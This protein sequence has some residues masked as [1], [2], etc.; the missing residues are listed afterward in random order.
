MVRYRRDLTPG[1][2]WFFTATLR[3]RQSDLLVRHIDELRHAWQTMARGRPVESIATVVLPD[4]IH[5]LWRLPAD[6]ADYSS[7]W[8]A[9][10]AGFTRLLGT[11]SP[12]QAR[13]WEHRIRD[14]EDLRRH[15]DYIHFNPVRHGLVQCVGDWPHSS[16][17]RWVSE[18]RL[19]RAW[20]EVKAMDDGLERTGEPG[21]DLMRKYNPIAPDRKRIS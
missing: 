13:F 17:H 14:D 12:W 4:H 21:P 16:V 9:W 8:R 10:K 1:A 3:D 15:I 18:G 20:L 7:R 6:D 2:T 19:P 5:A 11:P